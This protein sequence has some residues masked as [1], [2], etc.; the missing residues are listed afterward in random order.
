MLNVHEMFFV[1]WGLIKANAIFFEVLGLELLLILAQFVASRI[2]GYAT[3]KQMEERG[4]KGYSFMQHGGMWADL[5]IISPLVAYLVQKYS[6]EYMQ[7][8]GLVLFMIFFWAWFLL[9]VLVYAPASKNIPEAHA[10]GG[11][12]TVAGYIHIL[13]ATFTTWVIVMAYTGLTTIPVSNN[14]IFMTSVLLTLWA[15]FGQAKFSPLWRFGV[16]EK[17]SFY[18]LGI[19]IWVSAGLY[20]Y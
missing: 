7:F 15:Y 19:A 12:V 1:V 10:H 17:M 5:F 4:V 3:K 16:Q 13:F 14:D 8:G 2:D 18:M 6:F 11:Y 20:L 9:A